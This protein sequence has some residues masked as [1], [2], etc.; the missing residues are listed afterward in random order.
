MQKCREKWS[1]VYILM[2]LNK[3][4]IKLSAIDEAKNEIHWF[5]IFLNNLLSDGSSW[6]IAFLL[7]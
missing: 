1:A 2:L 3:K 4:V 5:G 6:L 7:G